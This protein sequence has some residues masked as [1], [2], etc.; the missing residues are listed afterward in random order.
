[1]DDEG[2]P[3]ADFVPPANEKP[4]WR[5]IIGSAV[6]GLLGAALGGYAG[7]QLGMGMVGTALGAGLGGFLG[8]ALG[9]VLSR[10]GDE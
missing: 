2:S 1:M 9:F 5:P 3:V 8:L 10:G 4:N 6:G 7:S